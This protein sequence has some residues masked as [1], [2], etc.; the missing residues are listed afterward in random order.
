MA[1]SYVIFWPL[2][3]IPTKEWEWKLK[4]FETRHQYSFILQFACPFLAMQ[5]EIFANRRHPLWVPSQ[6]PIRE[7]VYGPRPIEPGSDAGGMCLIH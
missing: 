1:I 3:V 4:M 6:S 7:C 5:T 2:W